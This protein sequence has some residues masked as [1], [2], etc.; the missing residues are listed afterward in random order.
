MKTGLRKWWVILLQG[1][2]LMLLGIYVF[3]Q[4]VATLISLAFWMSLLILGAG[5]AGIIGWLMA[6]KEQKDNADFV[7][8]IASALFGMVLLAKI[9]FAMKLLTSLLGIWMVITGFWL[10][11]QG[12][13]HRKAGWYGWA[14][15]VAGILSIVAGVVVMFDLAAGAVVVSTLVGLQFLIG[16][17]GL[18]VL[19][20]I[21]RMIVSKAKEAA[22]TWLNK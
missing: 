16:G 22:S 6:A 1:I 19:A 10:A 8:S 7:W 3:N 14:A 12:W 20:L 18:V 11:Q 9:E 4:P 17:F 15:F 21:K 5:V 2:L 13:A